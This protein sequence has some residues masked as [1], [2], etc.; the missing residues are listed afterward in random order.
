MYS[1]IMLFQQ[2]MPTGGLL[3]QTRLPGGK[4]NQQKARYEQRRGN[5]IHHILLCYWSGRAE[6]ADRI[7]LYSQDTV[8]NLRMRSGALQVG[9]QL[10]K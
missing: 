10:A 7:Q 3:R 5:Y 8:V 9:K 1:P 6:Q 2:R 4:Q